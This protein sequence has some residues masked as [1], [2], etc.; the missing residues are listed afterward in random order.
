MRKI[1]NYWV[2]LGFS[3]CW[4]LRMYIVINFYCF[5]SFFSSFGGS[6]EMMG[7]LNDLRLDFGKKM[8]KSLIG[9]EKL[10]IILI[11]NCKLNK[12]DCKKMKR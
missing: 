6:M 2:V 9:L 5:V 12:E 10:G 1:K 3:W 4:L 8:K 7:S 11:V